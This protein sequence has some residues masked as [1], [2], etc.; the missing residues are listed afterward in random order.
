MRLLPIVLIICAA[1]AA[2]GLNFNIFRWPSFNLNKG[3]GGGSGGGGYG[4]GGYG[5]GGGGGYSSSGGGGGGKGG[6]RVPSALRGLQKLKSQAFTSLRNLKAPIIEG[7][8][9]LKSQVFELKGNLLNSAGSIFNKGNSG[10]GQSSYYRRPPSHY[11]GGDNNNNGYFQ[12]SYQE[13]S[14]PSTGYGAPQAPSTGYGAPQA[15]STEYGAPQAPS[16]SY[17]A[18][19]GP[20]PQ[21][22]STGYGAPQGPAPQ[23][24]ATGYGV[25]QGSANTL[26]AQ[27]AAPTTG[28][29]PSAPAPSGNYNPAPLQN[30]FAAPSAPAANN[31]NTQANTAQQQQQSHINAPLS[32][33]MAMG[34]LLKEDE[35]V[36]GTGQAAAPQWR[37]VVGSPAVSPSTDVQAPASVTQS[38]PVQN[39]APRGVGGLTAGTEDPLFINLDGVGAVENNDVSGTLAASTNVRTINPVAVN[40]NDNLVISPTEDILLVDKGSPDAAAKALSKVVD[41]AL[42]I[43]EA[44]T[45]NDLTGLRAGSGGRL[46]EDLVLIEQRENFGNELDLTSLRPGQ[47]S[48]MMFS[49]LME[50]LRLNTL[51]ALIRRA[52]LEAM[53][54]TE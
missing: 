52:N 12:V 32:A 14:A 49:G 10:G 2:S 42:L 33:A 41:A 34:H 1:S 35:V 31:Y 20:A 17:G 40:S 43:N 27:Q 53:L 18:P 19:Q 46:Q 23:A 24:P 11:G 47:S 50:E 25:P 37:P 45:T 26:A 51:I 8:R 38:V 39:T 44:P 15:P 16:S 6:F 9:N 28:F 29:R 30:S 48:N 7:I 21:A 13:P 3:G 22:P 36:K 5:G 54:T 4:G